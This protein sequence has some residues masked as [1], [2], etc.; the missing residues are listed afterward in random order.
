MVFFQ[1]LIL[2]QLEDAHKGK[3]CKNNIRIDQQSDLP[4]IDETDD[5]GPHPRS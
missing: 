2:A 3:E 4:R 1:I 5:Y